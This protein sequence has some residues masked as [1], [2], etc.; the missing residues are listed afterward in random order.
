MSDLQRPYV[1]LDEDEKTAEREGYRAA[2]YIGDLRSKLERSNAPADD[3]LAEL[4]E[5]ASRPDMNEQIVRAKFRIDVGDDTE[6]QERI[7]AV[8]AQL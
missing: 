1:E 5:I 2:V 6:W 4:R 7:D 3:V 8:A